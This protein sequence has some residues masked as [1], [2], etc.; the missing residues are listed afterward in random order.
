MRHDA[1]SEVKQHQ[2]LTLPLLDELSKQDL[3]ALT[4]LL[5]PQVSVGQQSSI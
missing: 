3:G 2:T 1:I 5:Q 4:E